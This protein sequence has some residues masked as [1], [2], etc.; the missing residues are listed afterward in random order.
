MSWQTLN[1]IL[2]MASID[3]QFAGELLAD[4]VEAI[5]SRGFSLQPHEQKVLKGLVFS[6]LVELSQLLCEQFAPDRGKHI[7]K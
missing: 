2:G 3:E 1:E 4:S 6:S 7:P 5:Q